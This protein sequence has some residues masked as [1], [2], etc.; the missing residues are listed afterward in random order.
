MKKTI[1]TITTLLTILGIYASAHAASFTIPQNGTTTV[2]T[3]L[4]VPAPVNGI[5]PIPYAPYYIASSTATSTLP[6]I[7]STGISTSYIC[8][9]A[10]ICRTTWPSGSGGVTAVTATWPIISSG[11]TTPNLT[12]GGLSTSTNLTAGQL[13]Y[14]TGA[15][16]IGQ[17]ATSSG[18]CST[19]ITC[20]A[21]TVVGSVAP[22][23]TLTAPVTIALG[24]TNNT[25]AIGAS[26]T[27][28]LSD[29]SKYVYYKLSPADFT[30][31][32]VS[33]WTN[34]AGYNSGTVTSVSAG[35]GMSFTTITGSGPVSLDVS[36][37]VSNTLQMWNGSQLQATGTPALTVGYLIA[38]TTTAST[39]PYASSTSLTISGTPYITTHK[40]FGM[41]TTTAG[42]GTTTLPLEVSY[43]ESWNT[44]RCLTDTGTFNVDIYFG[45]T[46][47]LPSNT[48][49]AS[50]TAGTITFATQSV[51]TGNLLKVDIGTA[52]SSPTKIA[53]TISMNTQ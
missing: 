48:I 26:S 36:K 42:T 2:G 40:S 14:A 18:T 35:T 25:G 23:F 12:W 4:T 16:T 52:A 27:A 39:F 15:N 5:R 29:G 31:P 6:N 41:S 22:V 34:D 7:S 10:D 11:G 53:C 20:S 33:Q 3:V 51:G 30:T 13:L 28:V 24:G 32:N 9:T 38:T 19:G 50:T 45:S 17:V 37:E 44:M 49:N 46:H 8:F 43:G 21:F 47:L 1:A